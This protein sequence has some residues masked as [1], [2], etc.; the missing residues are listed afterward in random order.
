MKKSIL[1][2]FTCVLCLTVNA[3]STETHEAEKVVREF[4]NNIS[5]WF[6]YGKS[7]NMTDRDK[8]TGYRNNAINL[9][10]GANKCHVEDKLTD[11]NGQGDAFLA[12][13]MR[14][15][16]K[17]KIELGCSLQ[18]NTIRY[19]CE[20]PR[21]TTTGGGTWIYADITFYNGNESVRINDYF[22]VCKNKICRIDQEGSELNKAIKY[23]EQK[24]Y[25][26]AFPIFQKIAQKSPFEYEAQYYAVV[27]LTLK[28][29]CANMDKTTRRNCAVKYSYNGYVKN[30][31]ELSDLYVKYYYKWKPQQ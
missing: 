2:I 18:I 20:E 9:T 17:E 4:F 6:K 11:L 13:W 19:N 22:R 26:A 5:M 3:R 23:Y 25:N 10:T 1:L 21:I 30:N 12:D 8:A 14:F 31:E 16:N 15:F 28:Q 7:E 29:G 27:M 24:N